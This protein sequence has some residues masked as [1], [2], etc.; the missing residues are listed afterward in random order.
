MLRF[1]ILS[2]NFAGSSSKSLRVTKINRG[3]RRIRTPKLKRLDLMVT[4]WRCWLRHCATNQKVPD[5]IPYGVIGIFHWHNPS[6]R[7]G[8][9]GLTQPLT[10]IGKKSVKESRNRSG[11]A[12]RVP[13]GLGS[14]VSWHSAREGGEVFSFTHRPPL[15]PGNVPGTHFH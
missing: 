14:Q 2:P 7:I 5:S 15:P 11:V 1:V 3:T 9:L 6:G 4:R 12:Q 8:A 10:D 13:G